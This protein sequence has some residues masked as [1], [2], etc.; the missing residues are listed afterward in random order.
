M[1]LRHPSWDDP[2]VYHILERRNSAYVVIVALDC[3]AS[4]GQ[5]PISCMCD[6]T[7]P[8]R[9]HCMPVPTVARICVGGRIA[10]WNGI[11]RAATCWLISTMTATATPCVMPT[12]CVP[13]LTQDM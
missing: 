11:T 12:S 9:R 7:G 3:L 8:I 2:A 6:F 1:E 5:F 13:W 10:F 4:F